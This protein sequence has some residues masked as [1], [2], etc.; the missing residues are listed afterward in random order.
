MS[1]VQ[2]LQSTFSMQKLEQN[3]DLLYVSI[4]FGH[5][6]YNLKIDTLSKFCTFCSFVCTLILINLEASKGPAWCQKHNH[7][8]PIF[9]GL[10]QVI[11]AALFIE[12]VYKYKTIYTS[13]KTIG[14]KS[15][16]LPV[17]LFV[18]N[19]TPSLWLNPSDLKF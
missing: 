9:P 3:S 11:R 2:F 10:Y 13:S 18:C 15:A 8:L 5:L 6:T 17:C 4:Y 7:N 1:F 16:N 14:Y 12:R 19:L